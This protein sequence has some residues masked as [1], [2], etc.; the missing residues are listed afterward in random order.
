M[1][2]ILIIP[3]VYSFANRKCYFVKNIQYISVKFRCSYK[4]SSHH[5]ETIA[6]F[7]EM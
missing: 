3:F 7:M 6:F 2:Y 4:K 5:V 1:L